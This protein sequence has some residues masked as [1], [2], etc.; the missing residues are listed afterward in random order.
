[1]TRMKPL[2]YGNGGNI[3]MVQVENEYGSFGACDKSYME[4]LRDETG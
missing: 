4:W 3:I 1:M 2:L